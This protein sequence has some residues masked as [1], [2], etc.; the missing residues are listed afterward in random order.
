[1][2]QNETEAKKTYRRKLRAVKS[3]YLTYA[4]DT[5]KKTVV[6]DIWIMSERGYH[7]Q[8]RNNNPPLFC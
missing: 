4:T 8:S 6:E 5:F 2:Q 1:M 3:L 7:T